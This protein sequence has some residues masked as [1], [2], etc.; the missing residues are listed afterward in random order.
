MD[1][2]SPVNAVYD[3]IIGKLEGTFSESL[4]INDAQ[5][6]EHASEGDHIGN[7]AVGEIKCLKECSTFP[8][9]DMMLPSSSSDEEA[10]ASPSKQSPRE[11]YSCSAPPKH[12]YAMKGGRE[13]EGGSQMKL[14]VTWA[15]DVSDPVPTLLSHTVKNKKQQKPRIK[16]SQKKNGKG[17]K[18]SYSKRGSSKGKLYRNRWLHSHD[19]VFEAS[20]E[21]DDLNAVNHDSYYGTSSLAYWR[22]AVTCLVV[23]YTETA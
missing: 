22:R 18:V 17:Q 20:S 5:K 9:P 10:D 4:H 2:R 1:T 3:N 16:K 8:C 11:N 13:K 15:P 23:S 12:V 19:E 21:L 14:T 7:C 6:S